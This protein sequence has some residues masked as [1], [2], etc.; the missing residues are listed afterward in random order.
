MQHIGGVHGKLLICM[1]ISDIFHHKNK[2]FVNI[3]KKISYLKKSRF[4]LWTFGI[5]FDI[6][7]FVYMG[8]VGIL[9]LYLNGKPLNT[10]G[11]T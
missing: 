9:L 8:E 2:Y 6:I 11:K 10:T 4:L 1:N 7:H 3:V 5:S